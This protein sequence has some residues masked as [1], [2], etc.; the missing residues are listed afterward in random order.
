M[1]IKESRGSWEHG[2]KC[3]RRN[4]LKNRFDVWSMMDFGGWGI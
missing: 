4:N 3:L 2:M 1:K